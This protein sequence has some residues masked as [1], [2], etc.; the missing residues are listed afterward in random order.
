MLLVVLPTITRQPS[1]TVVEVNNI[2]TFE[3]SVRSYGTASITWKKL[4][5]KLPAT[6][7]AVVTKSLN[8][9]TSVLRIEKTIGYYE[10]YYY[11][12]SENSV[13]QVNSSFAYCKITGTKFFTYV[14]SYTQFTCNVIFMF[15]STLSR[16]DYTT[17]T[18]CS[19]S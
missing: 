6:A 13:G 4:K 3:C 12:I 2:A 19:T 1:S 18:C 16:N 11:C 10:G 7:N 14:R 15:Y 8:Q 5:S 9:I 17:R